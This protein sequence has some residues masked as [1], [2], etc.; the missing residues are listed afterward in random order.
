MAF[1]FLCV[2]LAS[3]IYYHCFVYQVVDRKLLKGLHFLIFFGCVTHLVS[4][5]VE[6][7][8]ERK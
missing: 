3:K 7:E 4:E 1:L 5:L 6:R 2:K 8:R